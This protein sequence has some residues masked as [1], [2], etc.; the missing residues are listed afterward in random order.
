MIIE[1]SIL[2][3]RVLEILL[4]MGV[5]VALIGMRGDE[6]S[7]SIRADYY[8]LTALGA[9][10]YSALSGAIGA[11][12]IEVLFSAKLRRGILLRSWGV[13]GVFLV[14]LGFVLKASTAISREWALVW[15]FATAAG[16]WL[17][18]RLFSGWLSSNKRKGRFDLRTVVFGGGEQAGKLLEYLRSNDQLTVRIVGRYDDRSSSREDLASKTVVQLPPS[19]GGLAALLSRIRTGEIDQVIVALPWALEERIQ[20]VVRQ[21]ALTPVRIRLAPDL[22]GFAYMNKPFAL[23]GDLPV[24]TLF[25]RP[26]S[27]LDQSLKWLEDKL[28][29]WIF[30]IGLAPL[31]ALIAI[32]IKLDSPGP[33]FFRQRR[34]GFND[35]QFAIWKFRSMHHS[36]SEWDSITQASRGDARITRVGAF[37]RRTSLDELPQLFNVIAGEMS[38]VGP[39]PHAP[40]TKAGQRLF[41]EAVSTYAARHRVKPGM[42]GWAQVRGWRGPTDTEEKLIRRL[43]HDLYYIEN[44]S[45]WFDLLILARTVGVAFAP[46]NAI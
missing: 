35:R 43:D 3:L 16:L 36:A 42:T 33:I 44:W 37:L 17:L 30:L 1:L 34:E 24:L 11:Y 2:V 46:K 27:G 18:R 20:E 10:I 41:R 23:L 28:L 15:F 19:N 26:I 5:G 22:V 32:A 6:I 25:D 38:L 7:P 4:V 9:L 8:R 21:L 13:T 45:V 40:S 31:F 14:T 39:R 29:G 12:D